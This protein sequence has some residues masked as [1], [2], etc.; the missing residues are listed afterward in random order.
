MHK[1]IEDVCEDLRIIQVLNKML[2]IMFSETKLPQFEDDNLYS[3]NNERF[4]LFQNDALSRGT[5]PMHP[6][7]RVYGSI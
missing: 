5:E 3:I 2:I 7:V 1:H 6:L 4:S